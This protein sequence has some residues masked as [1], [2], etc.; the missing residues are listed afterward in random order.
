[1]EFL[2]PEK[3]PKTPKTMLEKAQASQRLI[4]V[5]EQASLETV[6]LGKG[7]EGHYQLLNCDDHQHILKKHGRDLSDSRPDITHQCLLALLDSPLNKAGK[8]QNIQAVLRPDGYAPRTLTLVQLLHKLSIR[9]VNGPDKLLKVIANPIT[10]HLP[11]NC[12]KISKAAVLT[13]AMS[14]EVPAAPLSQYLGT[15]PKDETLVF[16][17]GAMAHGHD[18]WVDDIIDD[19]ISISDYPLSAAVTC[20]KLVSALG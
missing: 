3:P 13:P 15:V 9:A 7:K 2:K 20:S 14:S 12:R 6:K 19:K 16:F 8:M 17:I 1:M 4:V 5:L 11:P 10:D 18:N